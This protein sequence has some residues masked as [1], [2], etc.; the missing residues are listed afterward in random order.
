[1][2]HPS[3]LKDFVSDETGA[4]TVDFVVLTAALCTLGFLAAIMVFNGAQ[5][6]IDAT[7][8]ALS[9]AELAPIGP[10]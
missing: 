2:R 10:L 1:M 8:D 4:V 9:S 6:T 5:H 7:S 3:G